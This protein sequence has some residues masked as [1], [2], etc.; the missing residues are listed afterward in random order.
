MLEGPA[1]VENEACIMSL[2]PC[3]VHVHL[4]FWRQAKYI[5]VKRAYF[6]ESLL[7]ESLF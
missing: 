6:A 5:V 2:N 3:T 4:E 7:R 1:I